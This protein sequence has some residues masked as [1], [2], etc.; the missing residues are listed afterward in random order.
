MDLPEWID[1]D[2]LYSFGYWA[3]T[4]GTIVAFLLGFKLAGT[5]LLGVNAGA[6]DAGIGITLPVKIALILLTPLVSYLVAL[7]IFK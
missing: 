4:G 5:G 1:T 2:I 6:V 7:K 3:I